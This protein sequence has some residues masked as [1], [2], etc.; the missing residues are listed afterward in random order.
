M[1][2]MLCLFLAGKEI[3]Q[4]EDFI[5]ILSKLSRGARVP[6][7]FVSHVDRRRRKSV[8]VTVDRH[9]WYAQPQLYTR[10]DAS[11]LWNLSLG[12]LFA[13]AVLAVACF[14]LGWWYLFKRYGMFSFLGIQGLTTGPQRCSFA[15]L[16]TTTN[17]FN[18]SSPYIHKFPI[19]LLLN[20]IFIFENPVK[21]VGF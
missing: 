17:N 6:L 1:I 11:G 7:E 13:M 3:E 9:E 16:E 18:S 10:D 12:I 5:S 2:L 4:V 8:L 21:R 15:E 19:C 14:G 20:A